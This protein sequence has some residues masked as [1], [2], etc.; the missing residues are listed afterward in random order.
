MTNRATASTVHATP[1]GGPADWAV[2]GLGR[3]GLSC[4]RFLA[5]RG[6][7]VVV[8]D[9]RADPPELAALAAELPQVEV[10]CGPALPAA[11]DPAT[12]HLVLSPGVPLDHPLV[13]GARTAGCEILG[14]VE[15]FAR[16]A[17][18]PIAAITGSNGKSTVTTL[19]AR[20]LAA[21]GRSVR[22]GANLGTPALDLLI[23]GE[24]D[25][26]VLELSSFQLELTQRLAPR[27]ACLLNLSSDHLDRHGS[28][29][30]Y[31]AAKARIF[32]GAEAAVLNADEPA[33]AACAERV[34]RVRWVTQGE[35][36]E[37]QY[38]V[39]RRSGERWLVEGARPLLAT[40][41]LRIRGRHNEFNALAAIA[42]ADELGVPRAVQLAALRDFPGLPHRCA[43]VAERGGVAWYN[44]SKG[45]NVGAAN[46]A[47][48]GIFAG[49]SGVLI[50]GGQGKG[51]DFRELRAALAGRVHTA[52]LIGL[53][54]PRL[55][56]AIEDIVAVRFATGMREAVGLAAAAVAPGECVLLSPACAS[57]DMFENYEARGRAFEEAVHEVLGT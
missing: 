35:P 40:H 19:V 54:A 1:P 39:A 20:M 10:R 41:E 17:R 50:A 36:A 32:E 45:T 2:F 56:A 15:L 48:A 9:T 24:P 38:G 4:A 27:V 12:M 14:D 16:H 5:A 44:D 49:G 55:A 7:Q 53:D 43:L 33:V 42:I 31:A 22:A 18:A 30:A 47:I 52:I 28:F 13:A 37:G 25:I 21:A 34:S 51:A 57:L 26:Y 11:L 29:E 6:L 8:L 23:G 46:A 3:T